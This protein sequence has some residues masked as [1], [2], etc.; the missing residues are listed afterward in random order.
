MVDDPQRK[1]FIYDD[2]P[3]DLSAFDPSWEGIVV[4]AVDFQGYFVLFGAYLGCDYKIYMIAID[5]DLSV[6]V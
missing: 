5:S 6:N 4:A 1:A 3:E 2:V